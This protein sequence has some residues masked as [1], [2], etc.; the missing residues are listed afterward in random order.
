M[1]LRLLLFQAGRLQ[2]LAFQKLFGSLLQ[3]AA[4]PGFLYPISPSPASL[5]HLSQELSGQ[6]MGVGFSVKGMCP[7]IRL[8]WE[9]RGL[10]LFSPARLYKIKAGR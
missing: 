6:G 4:R 5:S 8:A 2:T 9:V 3:P 10:E 1:L 7:F